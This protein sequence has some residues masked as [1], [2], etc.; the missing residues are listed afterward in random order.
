MKENNSK[1]DT[2]AKDKLISVKPK[3]KIKGF[4][5]ENIGIIALTKEDLQIRQ[6]ITRLSS[7]PFYND[8]SEKS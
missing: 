4:N 6:R 1:K 2:E 5:K 8:L 7:T 3:L